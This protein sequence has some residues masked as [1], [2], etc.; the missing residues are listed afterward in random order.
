MKRYGKWLFRLLILVWIMRS[1]FYHRMTHLNNEELEWITNH[2]VGEM[3]YFQAQDGTHD[4][5]EITDVSTWNSLNPINSTYFWLGNPDYLAGGSVEFK[6]K[7]FSRTIG[8]ESF[9][10][11]KVSNFKPI[12]YRAD[13]LDRWTK[14]SLPINPKEMQIGGVEM[15]DVVVFDESNLEPIKEVGTNRLLRFAWSKKYG[16]VQ[17]EIQNGMVYNRTWLR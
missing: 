17:Y 16:L 9:G 7:R 10:I 14:D 4:T 8:H 15:E 11:K 13:F 3:M 2:S 5:I 12:H 6:S 1:C